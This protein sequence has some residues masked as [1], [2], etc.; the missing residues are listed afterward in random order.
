MKRFIR[1]RAL[2]VAFSML[3]TGGCAASSTA[4]SSAWGEDYG[5]LR[6]S[7]TVPPIVDLVQR[8]AGQST[9]VVGL[10][11]SGVDSHTYEPRPE[12][13]RVLAQTELFFVPAGQATP[14]VTD[15]AYRNL[16]RDATMVELA[17]AIP[18][19]E[20]IFNESQDQI[21]SHGHGHDVN[22]HAWTN[23]RYAELFAELI[24][25]QLS[26]ADPANRAD[27]E[28]N[29]A[30][31]A[32]ELRELD[33]A[34]A[35]ALETIPAENRRLVVYHDSWDY[36][37][38]D[39]GLEVVGTIQAADLAEPSAAEVAAMVGQIEE[40]GVPAFFGSEVFPSDVLE[41]LSAE[42][43]AEYVGDLS[44]DRLPGEV[45][46]AE[47]SYVGMMVA[48]VRLMVEAL[49]GDPSALDDLDAAGA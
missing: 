43:G 35:A 9:T 32:A 25:K 47:H 49:G 8:V 14:S 37:A 12:D 10:V 15:L 2:A 38:R 22:V 23:P 1:V 17:A 26:E 16:A 20:Y 30:E 5:G 27:Y 24:A 39:Y 4:G 28:A 3:V 48:N 36:F 21:A 40:A 34:T 41:T 18:P 42:T 7:A 45:G 6:V 46:D 13:A 33:E 11:P 29:A 19:G 31:L 44:D